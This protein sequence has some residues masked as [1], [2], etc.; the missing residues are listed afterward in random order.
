MTRL[1]NPLFETLQPR[2]SISTKIKAFTLTFV[3]QPS[4]YLLINNVWPCLIDL[5][6]WQQW[7]SSKGKSNILTGKSQPSQVLLVDATYSD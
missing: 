3:E 7:Q 2:L 5:C 4:Q 1:T 6:R